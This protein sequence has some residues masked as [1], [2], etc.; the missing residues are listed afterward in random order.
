MGQFMNEIARQDVIHSVQSILNSL[1]ISKVVYVDDRNID[2]PVENVINAISTGSVTIDKVKKIVPSLKTDDIDIISDQLRQKWNNISYKKKFELYRIIE[3]SKLIDKETEDDFKSIS[4]LNNLVPKNILVPLSPEKWDE[5]KNKLLDD[6]DKTLFLFD[7]QLDG[8]GTLK[9]KGI[10][11]LGKIIKERVN[12]MCGLLTHTI[13]PDQISARR[14]EMA[15]DLKISADRFFIIPKLDLINEPILFV[16]YLK[17]TI[18]ARDFD[19]L[20]RNMLDIISN[21]NKNSEKFIEDIAIQDFDHIIFKVPIRECS[22]EPDM[23]FR[24]YNSYQRRKSIELAY[25]DSDLKRII[26]NLRIISN[27]PASPTSISFPTNIWELQRDELYENSDYLNRNHL[28]LELGDI[29]EHTKEDDSKRYILLTQLCDLMIRKNGSRSPEIERFP[30]IEI[31]SDNLEQEKSRYEEEMPYFGDNYD[32]RWNIKFKRVH[33]VRAII[34]DLCTFNDD[35]V[36]RY[37]LDS[38][39]P[40]GLRLSMQ[41]YYKKRSREINNE[42]EKRKQILSKIKIEEGVNETIFK[43]IKYNIIADK[44]KD[45]FVCYDL[46]EL[47]N[48]DTLL[49]RLKRIGRLDSAKSADLLMKYASIIERPALDVYYG[50][51]ME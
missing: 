45:D 1:K 18:L 3:T 19:K 51:K 32:V 48:N 42:I 12:C 35:G 36:A 47:E 21:A 7:Q 23:F 40:E 37:K 14:L 43:T 30:I 25:K 10:N 22:W 49:Y 33:F 8:E 44:L 13:L 20:K 39:M 26:N 4:I 16:F 6:C 24:I 29:F 11:L 50:N 5:E 41:E 38:A 2:L 15:E 34:F 17:Y 9:E 27:I 28:P 31:I 46:D